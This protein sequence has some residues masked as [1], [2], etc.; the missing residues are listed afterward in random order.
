MCVLGGIYWMGE[1]I[2]MVTAVNLLLAVGLCIDYSA[3]VVHAFMLADGT[4]DQRARKALEHIGSSVVHGG[5]TTLL[6]TCVILFAQS[7]VFRIIS[8]MFL[9]LVLFGLFFGML[10]LPVLLSMCGPVRSRASR[11]GPIAISNMEDSQC[12]TGD[13]ASSNPSV[14]TDAACVAMPMVAA[15]PTNPVNRPLHVV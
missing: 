9:M 6:S 5:M 10:L 3:H 1:Y 13:G 14:M 7:Y 12:S 4:R 8:R 11:S 15:A 2:N